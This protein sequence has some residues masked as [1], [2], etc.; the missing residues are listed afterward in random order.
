MQLTFQRKMDNTHVNIELPDLE[1]IIKTA[2]TKIDYEPHN[3][4]FYLEN[5]ALRLGYT[6]FHFGGKD[7]VDLWFKGIEPKI[8]VSSDF[9]NM[10]RIPTSL[11]C[12]WITAHQGSIDIY[13]I[14]LEKEEIGNTISTGRFYTYKEDDDF[15]VS[16]EWFDRGTRLL[17]QTAEK[18]KL[19][20][21]Y[22]PYIK[23]Q[24]SI[25]KNSNYN[26]RS[27]IHSLKT[28]IMGLISE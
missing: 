7:N 1:K 17:K 4:G 28:R 18:Y 14:P 5:E 22:D 16:M 8:R 23:K 21:W 13:F 26:L 25:E 9:T 27:R 24:K 20:H 15:E 12:D 3:N 6:E 11:L 2:D 10:K 19:K